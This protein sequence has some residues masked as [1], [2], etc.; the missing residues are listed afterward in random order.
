V[1]K[2]IGGD[3]GG[4]HVAHAFIDSGYDPQAIYD[5]CAGRTNASAC[6]GMSGEAGPPVKP[7]NPKIRRNHFVY[8]VNTHHWKAEIHGR[9]SKVQPGDP[10]EWRLHGEVDGDYLRQIVAEHRVERIVNGR[11][12]RDWV[13]HDH[14]SGNHYLDAEV[15]AMASAWLPVGVQRIRPGGNSSSRSWTERRTRSRWT[16]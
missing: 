7:P 9:I 16:R 11:T 5:Y 2:T 13:M 6:K 8:M 4:F 3:Y 12:V 15:Y 1:D 14:G 10:N